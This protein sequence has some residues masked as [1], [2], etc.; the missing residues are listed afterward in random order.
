[1]MFACLFASPRSVTTSSG[2]DSMR[3]LTHLAHE[4]SPRVEVHGRELVVLDIDGLEQLWG[5]PRDIGKRLRRMAADRELQVRVAV[6]NTKMAA[7]LATQGRCG[8]TVIPPG[9]EA[10]ALSALP[11]AVLKKLSSAQASG[12]S[13][14]RQ[15]RTQ[16]TAIQAADPACLAVSVA[17]LLPVVRRWGIKT[18][19]DLAVLPTPDLFSRLGAGGVELQRMARGEDRRPLVPD[20]IESRFEQSVE[21]EWPIEGLEP[22]SFVLRRVLEPLCVDLTARG[23]AVGMLRV[24]LTLV[25][26]DIHERTLRFPKAVSDPKVLRTLILLD[27]KAHPP[28]AG[29]DRVT[30]TADPVPA[31]T[32]QF[33]LLE[34]A[35]P[36]AECLSTL[37]A[38]LTVLM[39]EQRCGSP[40]L[41]DTHQPGA[42]DMEPFAPTTVAPQPTASRECLVPVRRRFRIPVPA[43]VRVE[44]GV[45]VGVSTGYRHLAGG[46]ITTRAGPWRSSGQWWMSPDSAW[47]RDEWDIAL[48]NGEVYRMFRDRTSDRWFVEGVED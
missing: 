4:H 42:F 39:G 27:L 41:V 18:L 22:L 44:R 9:G 31:R 40:A 11:L 37:L 35:V 14:H 47:D 7:L 36:S 32:I 24:R 15:P 17:V 16:R 10:E 33:S 48:S 26:H 25:S 29:I 6:A 8:V 13:L 45:P 3:V 19:G 5:S 46:S 28:S 12:P 23:S 21:L 43:R 2:S 30:V 20:L 1:M 38:R 34:R